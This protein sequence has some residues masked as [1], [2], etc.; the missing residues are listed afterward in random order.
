MVSTQVLGR[1]EAEEFR[2]HH[3]FGDGPL[4][5][6]VGIVE[7][8]TG[9]DVAIINAPPE[10][11]GLTMTDPQRGVTFIAVAASDN[12]MRQRSSLAHELCHVLNQDGE[13]EVQQGG[14]GRRPAAE[15]KADAFARHLLIPR[16][17][18]ERV[19]EEHG[20]EPWT[21]ASL[22]DLVRTFLVSPAIAAIALHEAGA[23]PDDLKQQWMRVWTPELAARHGWSDYYAAL[24]EESRRARP[25]RRLL[26]RA[27]EGYRLGVVSPQQLAAIR[28]LTPERV[29]AE[30][31]SAG[32]RPEPSDPIWASPD[33]LPD[34]APDLT[35][36]DAL[37]GD[38][39][40]E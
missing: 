20:G 35:A 12:P 1:Q 32:V 16:R 26:A 15:R 21:E 7:R 2:E 10:E 13:I 3:H 19:M 14:N 23:I 27:I 5:D 18:I 8:T 24:Q 34:I 6:L 36:L 22:S 33:S 40:R 25:P 30:L 39:E 31:E 11:H 38:G 29:I 37:L 4:G 28:G 17:A 9:H